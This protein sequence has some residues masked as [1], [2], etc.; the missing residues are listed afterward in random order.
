MGVIVELARA[1]IE[2]SNQRHGQ[3]WKKHEAELIKKGFMQ[4]I[5]PLEPPIDYAKEL[6]E[7]KAEIKALKEK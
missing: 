3:L 1:K 2:E 6:V 7:L 4:P 5:P